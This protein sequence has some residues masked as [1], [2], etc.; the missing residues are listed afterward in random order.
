M[1]RRESKRKRFA[2]IFEGRGVN[3]AFSHLCITRKVL[4]YTCAGWSEG[5]TSWRA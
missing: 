3:C 4:I 1:A 2:A 5:K